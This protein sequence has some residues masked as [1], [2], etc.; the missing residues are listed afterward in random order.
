[1]ITWRRRAVREVEIAGVN[2]PGGAKLLLALCSGNHDDAHFPKPE[3]FDIGRENAKPHLSFG[4]GIHFCLG[5]PLARLELKIIL[6]EL[7]YLCIDAGDPMC[8]V[9]SPRERAPRGP[10]S[11]PGRSRFLWRPLVFL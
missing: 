2:V 9:C 3:R 4:F 5:A 10:F 6:E 7:H 1:M 8:S 11:T